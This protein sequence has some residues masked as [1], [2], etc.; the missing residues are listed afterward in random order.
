[1]SM[2]P[3]VIF[4]REDLTE[5]LILYEQGWSKDDRGGGEEKSKEKEKFSGVVSPATGTDLA[6]GEQRV[7]RAEYVVLCPREIEIE[8]GEIIERE[9]K[10]ERLEVLNVKDVKRLIPHYEVECEVI[11]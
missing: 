1:M 10:L 7:G 11:Q 2:T 9:G 5:P 4:Q 8:Q 6:V 3:D